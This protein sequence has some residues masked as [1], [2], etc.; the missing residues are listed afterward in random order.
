MQ[1]KPN[2]RP[3]SYSRNIKIEFPIFLIKM[4]GWQNDFCFQ[5]GHKR[6]TEVFNPCLPEIYANII[7]F[8]NSV[9]LFSCIFLSMPRTKLMRRKLRL[10]MF[11]IWLVE[12]PVKL[13]Q[14]NYLFWFSKCKLWSV[15]HILFSRFYVSTLTIFLDQRNRTFVQDRKWSPLIAYKTL[16]DLIMKWICRSSWYFE[17]HS[18]WKRVIRFAKP[19]A[20]GRRPLGILGCVA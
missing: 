17:G 14:L 7:P 1:R 20:D 15:E 19:V 4:I 12:R 16:Y 13:R 3:F 5:Q 18:F 10:T 8:S 6:E 11:H 2:F 9:Q